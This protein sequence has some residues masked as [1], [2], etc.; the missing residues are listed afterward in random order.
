MGCKAV[1]PGGD[2]VA[3]SYVIWEMMFFINYRK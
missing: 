3:V 2:E 1:P